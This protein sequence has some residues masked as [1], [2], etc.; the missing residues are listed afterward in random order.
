M[1][2]QIKSHEQYR[3]LMSG[4]HQMPLVIFTISWA[5]E[6]SL[7]LLACALGYLARPMC[8]AFGRA[9]YEIDQAIPY[10]LELES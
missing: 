3:D 8:A 10:P 1:C 7:I 2:L 5:G 4:C 6:L 9:P